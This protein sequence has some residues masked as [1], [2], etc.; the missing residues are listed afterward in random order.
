MKIFWWLVVAQLMAESLLAP[1]IFGLNPLTRY[2]IFILHQLVHSPILPPTIGPCHKAIYL[3]HFVKYNMLLE[4]YIGYSRIWHGHII[5]SFQNF[6]PCHCCFRK[7]NKIMQLRTDHFKFD[8][9]M[10]HS[11]ICYLII[12]PFPPSFSLFSSFQFQFLILLIVMT[13]FKQR[14]SGIGSDRSTNW[15]TTTCLLFAICSWFFVHLGE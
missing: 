3:V 5:I 6:P 10:V 1:E 12:G 8:E 15:A 9:S 14:I 4:S 11:I 2:C 7:N 13:G